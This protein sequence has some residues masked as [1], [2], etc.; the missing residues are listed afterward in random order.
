MPDFQIF[1]EK[2][3]AVATVSSNGELIMGD[4]DHST[5]Y[6]AALTTTNPMLIVPGE[7]GFQFIT[8]AFWAAATKSVSPSTA[9][10]IVIYEAHPSDLSVSLNTKASIDLTSGQIFSSPSRLRMSTCEG[11]V[12][13]ATTTD[14]TVNVTIV[15]YYEPTR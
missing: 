4:Y 14:P 5:S 15:G 3:Q 9:A 11:C 7:P 10:T 2:T 8:M 1:D 13:V 6:F 12:L